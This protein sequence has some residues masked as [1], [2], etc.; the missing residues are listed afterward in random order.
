MQVR[1]ANSIAIVACADNVQ[2]SPSSPAPRASATFPPLAVAIKPEAVVLGWLE[3]QFL[4][5][6]LVCRS[7]EVFGSCVGLVLGALH[8]LQTHDLVTNGVLI[9]IQRTWSCLVIPTPVREHIPIAVESVST[10]ALMVRP[11]SSS[12]CFVKILRA[13]PSTIP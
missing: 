5:Q 12:M 8:L 1:D 10:S 13:E 6:A 3:R 7:V 4:Q 2:M 11:N 9:H